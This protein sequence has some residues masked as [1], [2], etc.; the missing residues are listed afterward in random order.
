VKQAKAPPS[1]PTSSQHPINLPFTHMKKAY[2]IFPFLAMLIFFGFWWNFTSNYEAKQAEHA[3]LVRMERDKKLQKEADDR[4]LAIQE[5][6]AASEARKKENEAKE[7]KAQADRDARQAAREASEKAFRDKE[8]LA[9]QL[10]R[11]TKDVQ[12]EKDAIA[13]IEAHKKISVEEEAFLRKYVTMAEDNQNGL[14]RVLQ[15]IAAA[16]AARAAADAAAAAAA[17]K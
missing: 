15:K 5:A 12:T 7:A 8:K 16:D 9:R 10:E 1:K 11:L 2:V 13:K 17:K 3:K 14:N 4:K 6:I